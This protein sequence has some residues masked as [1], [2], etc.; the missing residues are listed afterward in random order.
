MGIGFVGFIFWT[1]GQMM[2]LAY[3]VAGS[4]GLYTATIFV[5]YLPVFIASILGLAGLG[6]VSWFL[7][8]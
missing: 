8:S 4:L 5:T 7:I 3:L 6:A 1:N 2:P